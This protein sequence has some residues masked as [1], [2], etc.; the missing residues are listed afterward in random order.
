MKVRRSITILMLS[1]FTVVINSNIVAQ[2]KDKWQTKEKYDVAAF[3]WPAYHPD[4]RFKEINVFPDGKGEWEAIY[5]AKPKFPGHEVPKVPLWGYEDETDPKVMGKKIATALDYGVNVMIFDWYWY[6]NK[7]FL[8]G[9]LDKGF[10]KAKNQDKMRFC[11]MWANHDHTSYLDPSNPDKSIIYWHGGVDRTIFDGMI[12]HII[13]DYFKQPN[14]YKIDGEPVFSIYELSTFIKGIG[15]AEKAKDALDYFRKKTKEAGF[16]GLHLQAILWGN[17]PTTL[18]D[19]PG[20]PIATQNETLEYFGFNSMTN[21]QWCH[22]VPA[23]GDYL[24]WGAKAIRKWA[25]WDTT[26][27]VPYCPHV[28]IGWDSNPRFPVKKQDLVVNNKPEYFQIYLQKAKEYIDRHPNQPRLITIN[29]WNEWAEGS[30][31]E[32]DKRHG[33]GYLEAVR[34]VF[35]K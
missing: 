18:N 24:A 15:G 1:L 16:P 13:N 5:K 29:A 34:E 11:L 30:Y 6:D 2:T 35:A 21:Y 32:P 25:E 22:F 26:F 14:Y 7:P 9:A 17:I 19:V 31:L 20:D 3:Y 28:S 27:T 8:E 12:E 10:L 33:F 23:K 4:P